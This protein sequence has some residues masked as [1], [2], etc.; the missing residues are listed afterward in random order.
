[1]YSEIPGTK[2]PSSSTSLQTQM[3]KVMASSHSLSYL[4]HENRCSID[5]GEGKKFYA[6]LRITILGLTYPLLGVLK[7]EGVYGTLNEKIDPRVVF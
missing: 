4:I 5:E 6:F 3:A 2:E 1:M 7:G